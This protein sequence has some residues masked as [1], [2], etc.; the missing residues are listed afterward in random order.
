MRNMFN[1]S[2]SLKARLYLIVALPAC[3]LIFFAGSNIVE[4]LHVKNEMEQLEPMVEIS[5]TVGNL[6]HNLQ[7][8]R[9]MTGG[10]INSRGE[11]F[12]VELTEQ[13]KHTDTAVRLFQACLQ[14]LIP[15]NASQTDFKSL[16]AAAD[17]KLKSLPSRRDNVNGFSI[18]AFQAGEYYTGVVNAL[19][20]VSSSLAGYSRNSEITRLALAYSNLLLAKEYTGLERALLTMAFSIDQLTPVVDRRFIKNLSAIN[21]YAEAF[22]GFATGPQKLFYTNAM[23]SS[24][25]NEVARMRKL[26]LASNG[27]PGLGVEPV[28][29]FKTATE[30]IDH[31]KAVEDKLADDLLTVTKSLNRKAGQSALFVIASAIIF[32]SLIFAV[33]LLIY[34]GIFRSLGQLRKISSTI[35]KGNLDSE[36]SVL[37]KDEFG[38]VLIDMKTMQTA[39]TGFVSALDQV[40]QKHAQGWVTEQLDSTKLPGV[41]GKMADEVNELVQSRIRLNRKIIQI[42]RQYAKGDF[43]VD[44]ETLPGETIAITHT[45]RDIKKALLDIGTEIKT[46]VQAGVNGDFTYRAEVEKYEFIFKEILTGLNTL[47]ATCD[48]GFS[49]VERVAKA[50]SQGDL[51]QTIRQDYPGTFEQMKIAVNDTAENLKNL[52]GEIKDASDIINKAANE[53]AVGNSDLSR[54]TEQQAA[55]LEQTAASMQ[56]LT[57]TVQHNAENANN[58]SKLAAGSSDIA[59]QG[60]Q[61]VNQVIHTMSAINESSQKIVDII[62]VID[63]IAFQ[64]NILALN[65]AVEAARAGEQGRGFAVVAGEVQ[66]LAQRVAAAAR[67]I[68]ELISSSVDQVEDG[69]RLVSYAGKKMEEIVNSIGSVT[70]MMTEIASASEQQTQGIEQVNL[71]I[72]Q[73]EDVTQQNAALVEQAA[74]AAESLEGQ[75][76]HLNVFIGKF[77]TN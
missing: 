35:A 66:N 28:Y 42:I 48:A 44:M 69:S 38:E 51:T 59:R 46:V 22:L 16:L 76:Q 9:G 8:E 10:F 26:A 58:A 72:G 17:E 12:N 62:S 1:I 65:A 57:S 70:A 14:N 7:K 21:I 36:I 77:V 29:W 20:Q 19:L 37:Q 67:E 64:T 24:A 39:L 60:V 15:H 2:L 73:M 32:L 75:T 27:A 41:Y 71:A 55:S 18:D 52:I 4:K 68:K 5:V 74:A 34:R 33:S 56:Q 11:K 50:L 6:I 40:S 63:G 3:L 47:L 45:M 13:R 49:D 25:S 53:I 61:V 43:S 23:Q 54:R 30:N 31:M